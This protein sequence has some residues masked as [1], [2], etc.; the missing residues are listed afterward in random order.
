MK[1]RKF[2]LVLGVTL[3]GAGIVLAQAPGVDIDP[4]KHANLAEAQQYIQQAYQKL[5]E[6]QTA[7]QEE[8]GGHAEKAKALLSQANEELKQA[9]EYANSHH[10]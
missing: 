4:H 8:L 10:R 1:N 9:A 5:D 6:A 2:A 7:N 3:A